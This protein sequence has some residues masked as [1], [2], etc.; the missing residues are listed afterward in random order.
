MVH[1]RLLEEMQSVTK[2]TSSGGSEVFER[3]V[4]EER[5]ADGNVSEGG[6]RVL[7]G[8]ALREARS[9]VYRFFEGVIAIAALI[10]LNLVT[11]V[12]AKGATNSAASGDMLV[13]EQF[14]TSCF[15]IVWDIRNASSA[16]RGACSPWCLPDVG[17]GVFAGCCVPPFPSRGSCSAA[18]DVARPPRF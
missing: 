7:W 14:D 15:Q 6:D 16:C 18:L 9:G 12:V 11:A 10:R 3:E 17:C 5:L 13:K 4:P 2:E 8:G 1:S